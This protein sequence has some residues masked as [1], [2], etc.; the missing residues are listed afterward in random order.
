MKMMFE[1]TASSKSERASFSSAGA[2]TLDWMV[3]SIVSPVN[4]RRTSVCSASLSVPHD[5]M[6][7]DVEIF[8]GIQKLDT[9]LL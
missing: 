7:F 5:G 2:P 8:S 6:S 1:Y 4:T 3:S 9:S